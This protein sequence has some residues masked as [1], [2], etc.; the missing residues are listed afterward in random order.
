[1]RGGGCRNDGGAVGKLL[2]LILIYLVLDSLEFYLERPLKLIVARAIGKLGL[3]V[4]SIILRKM[5]LFHS[6]SSWCRR[7]F[8]IS[9]LGRVRT[10][11]TIVSD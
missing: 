10:L 1:V 2:V 7:D 6:Y 3:V 11:I 5:C 4:I 9:F 8:T